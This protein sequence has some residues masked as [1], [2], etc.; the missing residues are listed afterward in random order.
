MKMVFMDLLEK[1]GG[2]W[3]KTK[4]LNKCSLS[5]WLLQ[6]RPACSRPGYWLSRK[7]KYLNVEGDR[8]RRADQ[9]PV[10][11]TYACARVEGKW[12]LDPDC[13]GQQL[14]HRRGHARQ[15]ERKRGNKIARVKRSSGILSECYLWTDSSIYMFYQEVKLSARVSQPMRKKFGASHLWRV[16]VA[17]GL[18]LT[19]IAVF[20]AGEGLM[21][22]SV[23]HCVTP[24]T[25]GLFFFIFFIFFA[26]WLEHCSTGPGLVQVFFIISIFDSERRKSTVLQV[27]SEDTWFLRAFS[28]DPVEYSWSNIWTI[29]GWGWEHQG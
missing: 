6:K 7:L 5:N 15:T 25:S 14:H 21:G 11:E 29:T 13:T 27:Q 12:T 18:L 9:S 24:A 17:P 22:V 3:G 16:A 8:C 28:A 10:Q 1:K 26:F 2:V 19:L 23:W 4:S 20:L